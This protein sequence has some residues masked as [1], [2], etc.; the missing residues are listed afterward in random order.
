MFASIHLNVPIERRANFK[1]PIEDDKRM[2]TV[3]IRLFEW[4]RILSFP[5]RMYCT[6]KPEATS[7]VFIQRNTRSALLR[8]DRPELMFSWV[9]RAGVVCGWTRESCARWR[10][11]HRPCR[12]I[13]PV[14]CSLFLPYL[15]PASDTSHGGRKTEPGRG[16]PSCTGPVPRPRPGREGASFRVARGAPEI[17]EKMGD[18][19]RAKARWTRESWGGSACDSDQVSA[20][21]MFLWREFTGPAQS[22]RS[23]RLAALVR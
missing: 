9:L 5:N 13:S 22:Q 10:S 7:S 16:L 6:V 21:R 15:C 19:G 20:I 3:C 8:T 12:L 4:T 18:A 11:P 14:V 17:G 2:Q 1:R 23:H